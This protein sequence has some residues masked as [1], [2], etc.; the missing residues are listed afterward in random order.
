[1]IAS[2]QVA[3]ALY[4]LQTLAV[5]DPPCTTSSEF[6]PLVTLLQDLSSLTTEVGLILA[7]VSLTVV[8]ILYIVAPIEIRLKARTAMLRVFAGIGV[9]VLAPRIVRYLADVLGAC[10]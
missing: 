1:M 9:L 4:S 7:V 8:G 3:V 10:Q 6:D 5:Y 2:T